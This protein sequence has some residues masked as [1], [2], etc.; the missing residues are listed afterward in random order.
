MQTIQHLYICSANNKLELQRLINEELVKINKWFNSNYLFIHPDKS[1][2]MFFGN[3]SNF[4]IELNNQ[5]I[6]KCGNNSIEKHFNMLGIRLDQK[7]N[8]H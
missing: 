3:D 5:T 8:W 7:L 2:T 1:R 4:N 6:T